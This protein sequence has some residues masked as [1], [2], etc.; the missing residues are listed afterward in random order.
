MRIAVIGAKGLP[1]RQGGIEHHCAGLYPKIVEKGHSVDF[2]ARSSYVDSSWGNQYD[3]KGVRIISL[4]SLNDGGTDA[5]MNSAVAAL[6]AG[7]RYDIVHFHALGPALFSWL[8]KL[9]SASTRVV[10]TCH[11][12]DWQRHKWGKFSSSIIHAGEKVAAQFADQIIV[13]S[14]NLRDYFRDKY[15]RETVYIPN[16][17]A[18]YADSD[19]TFSYIHSLGLQPQK[20]L[21]FLG[22]LVPE[23]CPHLLIQSFKRIKA[24]GWKLAIVGGNSSTT[25]YT[26]ELFDIAKGDPSIIFTGELRGKLLAEAVRAAGLF[27]LPSNLEGM[28]LSMLEAMM[29]G[30]P[31]VASDIEPH[32]KLLCNNRGLLFKTED[33]QSCS[34]ALNWAIKNTP[35]MALMAQSAQDYAQKQHSW[36]KVTNETLLAYSQLFTYPSA[37]SSSEQ[38][39]P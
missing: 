27:V 12:I 6:V 24:Q 26:H 7:A 13:V 39:V 5:F 15:G 14:D 28:P 34:K 23:K 32:Q 30:I 11:G 2:F 4:P 35:Q 31:I 9:R 1:P 33:L 10:V 18:N 16:A 8:P 20:Y 38:Y 19:P 25:A 3:Y 29:E 22:R 37:I 36:E 21:L 17:P